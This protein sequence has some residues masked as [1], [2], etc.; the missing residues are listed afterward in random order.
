MDLRLGLS[1]GCSQELLGPSSR[2]RLRPWSAWTSSNY[3]TAESCGSPNG[4]WRGLTATTKALSASVGAAAHRGDGEDTNPHT[5]VPEGRQIGMTTDV[6]SGP[7]HLEPTGGLLEHPEAAGPE[8]M[9]GR[10][11]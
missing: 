3:L 4:R 2:S 7:L 11:P 8:L 1:I 9:R 10:V 6:V 5:D